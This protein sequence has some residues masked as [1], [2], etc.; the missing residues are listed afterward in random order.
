MFS[1]LLF[2]RPRSAVTPG[3]TKPQSVAGWSPRTSFEIR[4]WRVRREMAWPGRNCVEWTTPPLDKAVFTWFSQA[5]QDG[6]PVSGPLLQAQAE[7]MHEAMHGPEAPPFLASNGWLAKFRRRHGIGQTKLVGEVRSAD[8]EAAA[9]F[10]P[11]LRAYLDEHDIPHEAVYNTDE[12]AL[13]YRLLPNKSL[14]VANSNTKT[15]GFKQSKD[16]VTLLL[17]TNKTGTHKLKPLIIGRFE[18]PRCLHHVNRDTLPVKYA[19]SRNAWMTSALFEQWFRS[20]FVPDVRRHLRRQGLDP[21]AVLL[22]DNCPAHPPAETLVSRDGN[23][24]VFFLP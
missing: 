11:Q 16:R 12:T 2:F 20:P 3:S 14:A 7:K 15:R 19:H 22:L 18:N 13:Y 1:L 6:A 23:I 5:T 8:H 4:P 9:R 17:T 21:R 24:T 10:P